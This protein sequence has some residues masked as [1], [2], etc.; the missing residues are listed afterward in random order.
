MAGARLADLVMPQPLTLYFAP[1]AC[2]LSAHIVLRELGAPFELV[3]V[4]LRNKT[5]VDPAREAAQRWLEINPKG[6]VPALRL[7]D[8][9]IITEA[10]VILGYLAD[11]HPDAH[12]APPHGTLA[13]VQLDMI[14]S[15]IAT[16][17]HKGLAPFFHPAFG[18]DYKAQV[19]QRL[20]Q[21]FIELATRLRGGP[22]LGGERFSIAD[23]YAFY[24]LRTWQKVAQGELATVPE[25]PAYYQRL[26]ERLSVAKALEV[27]G[28]TA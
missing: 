6:Y 1:S 28:I 11:T 25:L 27:E 15:F 5:L 9:T 22:Y 26:A 2:S 18:G 19:Q 20:A 17:L 4:D 14:V 10:Q 8:G 12:L 16:E 13:R 24:V 21:R 3:Q 23:A 7:P